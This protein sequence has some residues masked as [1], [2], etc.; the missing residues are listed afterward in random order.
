MFFKNKLSD[1]NSVRIVAFGYALLL[2][3]IILSSF[4]FLFLE[5]SIQQTSEQL[6][7]NR[8]QQ[9]EVTTMVRGARDRSVLLLRMVASSDVFL[10]DDIQR[11]MDRVALSV[12]N[13]R[14]NLINTIQE[15]SSSQDWLDKLY[16]ITTQNRMNQ[17]RIYDMMLA[18]NVE[19]ARQ[20][21]VDV[22]L[23]VQEEAL[24]I[25][26]F[27][28]ARFQEKAH[29]TEI[30]LHSFLHLNKLLWISIAAV[31]MISLIIISLFTMKRLR[32][33]GYAQ[34]AFRQ[35]LEKE[36]DKRTQE[37]DLDSNV[38][39]NIHEAIAIASCEGNLIK[40]NQRF[41]DFIQSAGI[42]SNNAWDIVGKVLPHLTT[43]SVQAILKKEGFS[44]SEGV[45]MVNH[46]KQHYF[47]DVFCV[48]GQK[49][50]KRYISL[51]LTDVTEL[52][53]TQ[54]HLEY[55]ANYDPITKIPNRH[56]FQTYLQESIDDPT[57]HQLNLF[58]IDLDNFK[59]IND[60]LGHIVGDQL[61]RQAA[62]QFEQAFEDQENVF[63]SRLGGDEFAVIVKGCD[64]S[65][66]TQIADSILDCCTKIDRLNKYSKSVSCSIGV[67]SYPKDG[68]TPEELMRHADFA[69]YK[70]KEQ[71][72]S[73]YCFF[74]EEM[75]QRLH[76]LYDMEH[77]LKTALSHQQLSMHFQPQFNLRTGQLT[78]AEALIRWQHEGTSISPA[79]FIPLA[80]KFG[81]IESI[82]Q[83]VI[84]SSIQQ[85]IDWQTQGFNLPKMAINI[86]AVQFRLK[87]FSHDLESIIESSEINFNQIDI[88]ITETVLMENLNQQ[89]T[90]LN[91]LQNKGLEVSIDDFG[92]GYSSLA[93]IK[94]LSV[95]RIKIDRSFIQDLGQ[96]EESD[97]IVFA[98]ITMG[99]SLGLK[100]L[101][102]GIETPQQLS[103]LCEMGCDEGQGYLLGYPSK[104]EE[105]SFEPI[106]VNRLSNESPNLLT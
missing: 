47:V 14:L 103:I 26:T 36:V 90:A 104:P 29:Q 105:F 45:V 41:N 39:H 4:L 97:S 37:I 46:Q 16:T 18:G 31:F 60:T 52:K 54:Q 69:M 68:E 25:L 87:N 30:K 8:E 66:L 12:V 5:R 2:I 85:L 101:A 96:S 73:Q 91:L 78:G 10:M 49:S 28:Q 38:L 20:F 40:T 93:Y 72:K 48:E 89:R 51:L 58:Y 81:L 74:S 35:Q 64:D 3:L 86:S 77:N 7:I 19:Q 50:D 94:H 88:E 63:V 62:K 6:K 80:E 75:K 43:E 106:N 56:Y 71:G 67:A 24:E 79:L 99:H 33:F 15:Q 57:V 95:D 59:W 55:L 32:Q 9:T 53:T 98:I 102:E 44:R 11:E 82:G 13:A 83:F 61:L 92:T 1:Q 65:C 76:Y 100:V 22:T 27:F 42:N 34:R 70:A 21:L 84:Q 23:P 17:D